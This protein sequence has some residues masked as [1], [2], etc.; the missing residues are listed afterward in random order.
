MLK[1][2]LTVA[3]RNMLRNLM[4]TFINMSGLAIG[5]ATCLLV[6]IFVIYETGFDQA[7]VNAER[8]YRIDNHY[9]M[10]NQNT[11]YRT[12][13]LSAGE[14]TV[15]RSEMTDVENIVR[16]YATPDKE[17]QISIGNQRFVERHIYYADEDLFEVFG[18]EFIEGNP[19]T[20]LTKP[21]TVV[22]T[23][24]MANKFFAGKPALGKT[25]TYQNNVDFEI[26]GVIRDMP[27]QSHLAV[28]ALVSMNTL[29]QMGEPDVLNNWLGTRCYTFVKLAEGIDPGYAIDRIRNL[30]E[31]HN[32][33]EEINA[34]Y[35][36]V[37]L[38]DIHL[39]A[40]NYNEMKANGDIKNIYVFVTICF[41]ML[42][43]VAINFINL[44]TARAMQR[45][46]EVGVRKSIGAHRSQ[47]VFQFLSESLL[48]TFIASILGFALAA[49]LMPLASNVLDRPF[50]YQL[51]F[52]A[53]TMI[54]LV[55][56][57]MAIGLLA[58]LYPA[59]FLSAFEPSSVLKGDI[60]RGN[61]GSKFRQS[62]VCFQFVITVFLI[63]STS[64]MSYQMYFVTN[65]R[66]GYN[67]DNKI[68]VQIPYSQYAA[69]KPLKKELIKHPDILEVIA[70]SAIPTQSPG[71]KRF[72]S[73][74]TDRDNPIMLVY[75]G[76]ED[77]TFFDF[78]QM[79]ISNGR[80]FNKDLT[81]DRLNTTQNSG[82]T[83]PV[84]FILNEKAVR[85]FGF[86]PEQSIGKDLEMPLSNN[87][88]AM[89]NIIGT[90][91]DT[92]FDSFKNDLVPMVFYI[93][94]SENSRVS[95]SISGKNTSDV[96]AHIEKTWRKILPE[97]SAKIRFV[98]AIFNNL[99]KNETQQVELFNIISAVSIFLSLLGLYGL[100]A[101]NAERRS[102]EIAVRKVLGASLMRIISLLSK[103]TTILVA[104]AN[105]LAWP[106]AYYAVSS[107]L[108]AFVYRV[109][110]SP[111]IFIGASL[112]AFS[113]AWLTLA[114]QA[115]FVMKRPVVNSLKCE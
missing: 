98:D 52:S 51:L 101:F 103:E 72:F 88:K 50:E 10:K 12:S 76:I 112:V 22:I 42:L 73:K 114:S 91:K 74:S 108:S 90:L 87:R 59:L 20:A 5:I 82:A 61:G 92:N 11:E 58:G 94:E 37:N 6:Y 30:F 86:T 27:A 13:K 35:H 40:H 78:Y 8:I 63:I 70:S 95:I 43:I 18:F 66:I 3:L 28:N 110:I 100:T 24:S 102:K 111:W 7:F 49:L 26:T 79:T 31:T 17:V 21:F 39:Y 36:L 64:F 29:P 1:N 19:T 97:E 85:E 44:S 54:F 105:L 45:A 99:Y 16:F 65:E 81:T 71:D 33:G 77:E 83:V 56:V 104:I 80:Q 107:W 46:K 115:V 32:A 67:T 75:V 25:L 34:N 93:D 47:L 84:S 96:L 23:Q 62:L 68:M 4:P 9:T 113:L 69:F 109:G 38:Q 48:T 60:T 14:G 53:P 57:T 15:L 55:L 89:G 2:Y 41:I 106:L